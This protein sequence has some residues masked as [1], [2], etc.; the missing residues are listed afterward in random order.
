MMTH[1]HHKHIKSETE[2]WLEK[3]SAKNIAKERLSVPCKPKKETISDIQ[4]KNGEIIGKLREL[5]EINL[6]L[7]PKQKKEKRIERESNWEWMER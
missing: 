2:I 6:K 3:R 4:T 1:K 5:Q 7:L